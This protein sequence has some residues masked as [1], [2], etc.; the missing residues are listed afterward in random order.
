MS[1][2]KIQLPE[3]QEISFEHGSRAS[4]AYDS[5]G[6]G[7][8]DLVLMTWEQDGPS[9]LF[10]FQQIEP[11]KLRKTNALEGYEA[12]NPII[13]TEDVNQDGIE[14]LI[15]MDLGDI[16]D[17]D[18]GFTGRE[19][20][21]FIGRENQDPIKTTLLSDAYARYSEQDSWQKDKRI[22]AKD[23]SLADIEND[24]DLDIWVES[25]GGMN[26]THHFLINN[27]THFSVDKERLPSQITGIKATDY[28]RY[29]RA[30]FED[31]N[32][33]GFDDLIFA[34]LRDDHITHIDGAS[35]VLLNDGNGFFNTSQ[36][37]P[38]PDFNNGFTAANSIASEDINRDG[39][40]DIII[41]HERPGTIYNPN[42]ETQSGDGNFFQV[43]VQKEDGSFIDKTE[44]YLASQGEWSSNSSEPYTNPVASMD[45]FDIDKDGWQDLLINYW[46]NYR[47][48]G[49]TVLLNQKGK[50]L[51]PASP[52]SLQNYDG[53]YNF[54]WNKTKLK[55]GELQAYTQ[56]WDQEVLW[57]DNFVVSTEQEANTPAAPDPVTGLINKEISEPDPIIHPTFN[58]K[59]PR[60]FQRKFAEKITNFNPTIDS[61]QI[62][63]GDFGIDSFA[64]FTTGKNKKI[65]KKKLAKQDFDLIYDRKKGGLYF[66]E[67]GTDKGF[68]DG[69]II[70][71]LKGAPDLNSDNLEFV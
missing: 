60:S 42:P 36:R 64:S 9:N 69:G 46:S 14:D 49:P 28:F 22:S 51:K 10:L 35:I 55:S 3:T 66:N 32:N 71:I 41:A 26:T 61:I 24:G 52:A 1:Q 59:K 2:Y 18:P 5:N 15:V 67:N 21:L 44:L 34:Q 29:R 33:D 70:A 31:L 68:G 30:H 43:L 25:S 37:L 11:G 63:S 20:M 57:T 19:P 58:I 54:F 17:G 47:V 39:L 6:N 40:K 62:D 8:T 23:F 7:L 12:D 13:K 16:Y 53:E 45:F 27:N 38:H 48:K 65:V 50:H 4:I 56:T